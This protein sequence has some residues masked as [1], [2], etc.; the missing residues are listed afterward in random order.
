MPAWRQV[1]YTRAHLVHGTV[2]LTVFFVLRTAL[3]SAFSLDAVVSKT[4][5]AHDGNCA[6]EPK[7]DSNDGSCPDSGL[8]PAH[9]TKSKIAIEAHSAQSGRQ[10]IRAVAK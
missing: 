3:G 4:T 6:P 8:E 2:W 1:G 7:L 5:A 10:I 9:Q